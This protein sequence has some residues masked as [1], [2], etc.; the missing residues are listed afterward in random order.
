MTTEQLLNTAK[1]YRTFYKGR[2]PDILKTE[3]DKRE[4]IKRKPKK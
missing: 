3:L 4:H 1:K 2:L